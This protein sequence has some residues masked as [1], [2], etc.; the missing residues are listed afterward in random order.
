MKIDGSVPAASSQVDVSYIGGGAGL[1][2]V[3]KCF[4]AGAAL[5]LLLLFLLLSAAFLQVIHQHCLN[6]L[7]A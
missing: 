7:L 5:F 6:L 3:I 1:V 4:A 2:L